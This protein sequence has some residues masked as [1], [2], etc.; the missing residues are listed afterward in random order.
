MRI[1]IAD[2]LP[3][4]VHDIA[5]GIH[6]E[7]PEWEILAADNGKKVV[8]IVSTE[9]VDIVLSDIRMPGMDGLDVL[10]TVREISPET[11][12]VLI[13]AYPLFEYAQKALKL[14]ASDFLLKPLDMLALYDTLSRL[15]NSKEEKTHLNDEIKTFL[16]K[17]LSALDASMQN[18]LRSTL[19]QGCVCSLSFPSARS[20]P[21]ANYLA[22]EIASRCGCSVLAAEM[23]A[24]PEIRRYVLICISGEWDSQSFLREVRTFSMRLGF[25]FGVSP[26]SACL[27]E[28]GSALWTAA[29][30]T[31]HLAFYNLDNPK[32][33]ETNAL[34][35]PE[36]PSAQNLLG[37]FGLHEGWQSSLE[38]M[39][40]SIRLKRPNADALV[41][42]TLRLLH[43]C[44]ELINTDEP[45]NVDML[46]RMEREMRYVLFYSEYCA[47]LDHA[48]HT[49]E[50]LYQQ[51]L[52]R[53]DPVEM[54]IAY[55]REHYM[56]PIT[57]PEVAQ[58]IHLTPNYLSTLFRRKTSLRFMEYVLQVRLEKAS[59]MLANTQMHIYEIA[60]AC[61]YENVGYF[62]R[63]Y[64]KA[65]GITPANFR[66]CFS[67]DKPERK[68]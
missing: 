18:R 35:L 50:M 66:R 58:K 9:K 41:H 63:V 13:T 4:Q 11:K 5:N 46:A 33:Q 67:R 40:S 23:D 8:E 60:Q 36:L 14:G 10:S 16:Q 49:L 32:M 28:E 7:W 62:I 22:A 43:D 68:K 57:L 26:W 64:Q 44:G 39:V 24:A 55:V 45:G 20:L 19:L 3:L 42:S 1:L 54:A 17:G 30:R 47:S 53:S 38:K 61:G 31:E 34:S 25:R 37:W 2:D 56:D 21:Q 27:S 6:S 65:H 12:F 59:E 15:T 51:S 52:E 48:M 29:V